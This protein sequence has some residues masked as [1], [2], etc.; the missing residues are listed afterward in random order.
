MVQV[1]GDTELEIN[2]LASR[3]TALSSNSSSLNLL[4]GT[5]NLEVVKIE[6][7]NRQGFVSIML[8]TSTRLPVNLDK[9]YAESPSSPPP[10]TGPGSLV[11]VPFNGGFRRARVGMR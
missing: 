8:A 3:L 4:Q 2:E 1:Y 10:A 7:S 11:V 6:K 5:E 9:K